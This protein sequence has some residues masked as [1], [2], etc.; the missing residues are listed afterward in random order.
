MS[1]TPSITPRKVGDVSRLDGIMDH[2]DVADQCRWFE[3][4]R[5]RYEWDASEWAPIEETMDR[6]R[7]RAQDPRLFLGIVGEFSSGKST[8]INALLR[9]NLLKTDILPATTCATTILEY[10]EQVDF[11]IAQRDGSIVDLEGKT[12]SD[13]PQESYDE[14]LRLIHQ[15]T[16]DEVTAQRIQRVYVNHPNEKLNNGLVMVDTPGINVENPRH[17]AVTE[18][19]VRDICDAIVLVVPASAACS[20]RLPS[21]PPNSSISTP[22]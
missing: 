4:V 15:Y 18:E 8:L 22:S 16:A 20:T 12:E 5:E 6:L 14:L 2:I 7:A 19:A 1:E 13:D 17:A 3:S 9:E 21:A 11:R 10:G